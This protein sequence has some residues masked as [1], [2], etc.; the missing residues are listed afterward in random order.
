MGKPER[1]SSHEEC[2]PSGPS[3]PVSHPVL[4]IKWNHFEAETYHTATEAA[5]TSHQQTLDHFHG[6]PPRKAPVI[7]R[8]PGKHH[9]EGK[10]QQQQE[11]RV[12]PKVGRDSSPVA[13]PAHGRPEEGVVLW[14][15][16]L[17]DLLL[18]PLWATGHCNGSAPK[19]PPRAEQLP[20]DRG[21]YAPCWGAGAWT[22]LIS[23]S[24]MWRTSNDRLR[25][26]IP[27][28]TRVL[29]RSHSASPQDQLNVTEPPDA[30]R[31]CAPER[32]ENL[33]E[34]GH[35]S[36]LDLCTFHG[37]PQGPSSGSRWGLGSDRCG[38]C[39]VEFWAWCLC[40]LLCEV[41]HT[42]SHKC[43]PSSW[44]PEPQRKQNLEKWTLQLTQMCLNH[45]FNPLKHVG[46]CDSN[47]A[48]Y[49]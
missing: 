28:H 19:T 35:L 13:W 43:T 3:K 31:C 2:L 18:P 37:L 5:A 26:Q 15:V 40:S 16:P 8:S 42:K 48:F 11:A 27:N 6:P 7:A 38:N 33:S 20:V 12:R 22:L 44:W 30:P 41:L 29:K 24:I 9:R 21:G 14:S 10:Q 47:K 45:Y 36:P 49:F 23:A 25:G 39:Q 32:W 17:Q 34:L 46:S 1:F 4:S